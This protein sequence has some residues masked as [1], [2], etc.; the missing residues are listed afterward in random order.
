MTF[1]T[2]RTNV[3]MDHDQEKVLVEKLTEGR[4]GAFF[5]YSQD[6]CGLNQFLLVLFWFLCC[7]ERL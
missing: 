3:H 4:G 2:G 5:Y 6:R 7:S 1:C